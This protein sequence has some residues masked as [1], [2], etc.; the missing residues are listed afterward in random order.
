MCSGDGRSGRRDAPPVR[1]QIVVP[2]DSPIRSLAE[3]AGAQVGFPGPE[4]LI[5]YK[6][7]YAQL[8]RKNVP[9]NVAFAAG[10]YLTVTF[11]SVGW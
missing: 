11:S 2:A 6:V 9:V 10:P 4:A 7:P 3:L 1:G 8:L 5:G